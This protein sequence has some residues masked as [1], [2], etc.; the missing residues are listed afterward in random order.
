VIQPATEITT[1]RKDSTAKTCLQTENEIE[2]FEG[3]LRAAGG[4][5]LEGYV[6]QA[7]FA[8]DNGISERTVKR[9]RDQ[10]D[11]LPWVAFGGKVFI[12]ILEAGEWLRRR[13]RHPNPRRRAG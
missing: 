2:T 11:G 12:P 3:K 13:V 1:T 8:A 10:P 7:Q 9:Y 5:I 4:F 6:Q